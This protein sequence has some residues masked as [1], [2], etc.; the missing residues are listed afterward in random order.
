MQPILDWIDQTCIDY[1]R[2]GKYVL[3]HGWVPCYEGLDNFENAT[4]EDWREARW[5][6][7]ME[8]WQ[9][10]KCRPDNVTV[11]VGHWHCSFGWSHIKHEREE[12]PNTNC[13]GWEKSFEPFV[14]D[15]IVAIDAC[16][17][18]SGFCNIILLDGDLI[19]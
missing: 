14:E 5:V 19:E 6:N 8:M 9:N 4:K 15:G 18:Y 2:I 3:C 11:I 17:A 13:E 1:Y 7:G 12:F 16:T 10:P